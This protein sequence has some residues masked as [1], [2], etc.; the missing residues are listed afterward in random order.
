MVVWLKI[1]VYPKTLFANIRK[2]KKHNLGVLFV[3][4]HA[5]V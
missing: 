1:Q 3:L 4:T 2:F 5:E